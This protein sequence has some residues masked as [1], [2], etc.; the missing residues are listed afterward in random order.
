MPTL[1][2]F[3]HTKEASIMG[4]F[5]TTGPNPNLNSNSAD[6]SDYYEYLP[7]RR[8]TS[9]SSSIRRS[10]RYSEGGAM[11]LLYGSPK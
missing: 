8:L 6:P 4:W 1:R 9:V 5:K 11:S 10:S 7:V 3:N 2:A